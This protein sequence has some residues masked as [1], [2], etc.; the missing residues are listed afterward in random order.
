MFTEEI[1]YPRHARCVL[2]RLRCH[3]HCLLLHSSFSKIG[4]IENSCSYPSQDTSHLIL[5]CSATNS[6]ALALLRFFASQQPLLL[7]L[8]SLPPCPDFSEGVRVTTTTTTT[9]TSI[10]K[11]TSSFP[12]WVC[13]VAPLF[14]IP[15][16]FF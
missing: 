14:S 8:H 4:R 1:G 12:A 5:H 16:R 9:A 11:L 6:C 7:G 13:V 15:L 3:G 2:S 10:T